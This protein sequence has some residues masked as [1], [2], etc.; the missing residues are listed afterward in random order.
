MPTPTTT[1]A[2]MAMAPGRI[3]FAAPPWWRC[4]RSGRVRLRLA[5]QQAGDLAELTADLVDHLEGRVADGGHG[6]GGDQERQQCR[7]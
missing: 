3:I 1:G 6:D 5:L 2:A 4:P 7:R